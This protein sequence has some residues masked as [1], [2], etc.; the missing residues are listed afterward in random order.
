LFQQVL[1]RVLYI[2]IVLV[3]IL[4]WVFVFYLIKARLSG[5]DEDENT[6]A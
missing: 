2:V 3:V 4:A 6:E 1:K 5:G